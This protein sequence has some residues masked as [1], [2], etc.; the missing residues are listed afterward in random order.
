[1]KRRRGY[2]LMELLVVMT[3]SSVMLSV[4]VVLFTLL[5]RIE[6]SGRDHVRHSAVLGRLADQFRRD[7]HATPVGGVSVGE[8]VQFSPAP[9][10]TITYGTPHGAVIRI[11]RVGSDLVN[12]EVARRESFVLPS[13]CSASIESPPDAKGPTVTL[14]IAPRTD[15]QPRKPGRTLRIDALLGR[16]HRFTNPRGDQSS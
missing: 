1:M 16:D 2:S 14:S 9:D 4:T 8:T 12:S 6:R 10:R 7:V 5:F 13:S 11:E 3:M 15:S